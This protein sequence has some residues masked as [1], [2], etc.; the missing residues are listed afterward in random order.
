MQ[1]VWLGSQI[2]NGY[3]CSDTPSFVFYVKFKDPQKDSVHDYVNKYY[4]I[5]IYSNETFK[6]NW[7]IIIQC[8]N[9]EIYIFDE[10]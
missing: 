4:E 6:L 10:K 5:H 3:D 7:I 9:S 1:I 2:V 8:S